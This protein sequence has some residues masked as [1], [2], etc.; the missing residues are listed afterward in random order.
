MDS[1]RPGG[2]G[3]AVTEPTTRASGKELECAILAA[4][5][6][7]RIVRDLYDRSAAATYAKS[8]GSVVTDADLA[9]DRIIRA[10]LGEHF[11][12]DPILT[13]E[14][15][16]DAARLHSRRCW[17]VDPIDGTQQ[18]VDRTGEFDILVAL[19]VDG[20]PAVAVG[21]QPPTGLLCAAVVGRGAWLRRESQPELFRSLHLVPAGT[22]PRLATSVWIGGPDNLPTLTRVAARLGIEPPAVRL[23]G[24]S[25]RIFSPERSCDA[26]IGY[27]LG[28]DQRMASEW[29]FAVADLFLTEAGGAVSDLWGEPLRYNK[30]L[31]VN[32]RGIVASA[33]R[34]T[35]QRILAALRSGTTRSPGAF[36]GFLKRRGRCRSTGAS[37]DARARCEILESA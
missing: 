24:L 18:F 4:T 17:I 22:T 3:A 32:P 33:D 35:H 19:V 27:R 12:G 36:G 11:P 1:I 7:G 6:A 26:L 20:R 15:A 34:A 29:D 13:E 23:T 37:C 10:I 31:P 30:P 16:D 14:G 5:E 8:D 2:K 25:P 9:A 28:P 21:F